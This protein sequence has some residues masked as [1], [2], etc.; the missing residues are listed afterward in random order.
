MA[1]TPIRFYFE[2]EEQRVMM[3]VPPSDLRVQL[4]GG[5]ETVNLLEGGDA[6]ILK[7]PGLKTVSLQFLLP[8][9]PDYPFVQSKAKWQKPNWYT[10]FWEKIMA[11]KKPVRAVVTQLH[12]DIMCTIESY[13]R[14]HRPGDPKSLWCAMRLREYR[15]YAPRRLGEARA[16]Q[17]TGELRADDKPEIDVY[18]VAKGDSL[19]QIAK[20]H[21]GDGRRYMEIFELNRD[22]IKKPRLI[23]PG[24]KLKMPK[25]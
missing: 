25:R 17:E 3:P 9:S 19:W 12:M 20:Q 5:G 10:V 1:E 11:A 4:D 13:E 2:Y 15:A 23:R 6:S 16:T 7:A 22:I 18:T 14:T 8:E 21:L 24:W